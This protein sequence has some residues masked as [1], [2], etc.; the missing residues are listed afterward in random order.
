MKENKSSEYKIA[1]FGAIIGIVLTAI[2]DLVKEKPI[3]SSLWNI[4][5]W[6]WKNIFEFTVSIWQILAVLLLF[7]LIKKLKPK[8]ETD[9]PPFLKYVTDEFDEITWKW[10]WKW[11]PLTQ[12]WNVQ[13]LIPLCNK[14]GTSTLL[15]EE[16]ADKYAT[17][18][19][20][21]NFMNK[22]KST[23]KIEAII[24]DNIDRKLYLNK[25]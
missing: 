2:Y 21:E 15:N 7:Y 5:K 17:C 16:Y 23:D 13:D 4:F 12:Q 24:I 1:L 25:E 22:L 8:K 19:R 18:P 11:N 14:C 3:L 9:I 10:K 20:C 6:I